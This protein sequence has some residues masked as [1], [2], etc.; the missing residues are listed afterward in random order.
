[1]PRPSVIF[2]MCLAVCAAFSTA[3][4]A[5]GAC[6]KLN[7][8][9][10]GGCDGLKATLDLKACADAGSAAAPKIACSGE[11]ATVTVVT[12]TNTYVGTAELGAESWGKRSWQAKEVTASGK[13]SGVAAVAASAAEVPFKTK[14]VEKKRK[15]K[16]RRTAA[17]KAAK[18]APAN[19]TATPP[20]ITP[21]PTIVIAPE[22]E[23]PP[24]A[25]P[26]SPAATADSIPA[27]AAPP[28]LA[29][30][31]EPTPVAAPPLLPPPPAPAPEPTPA[32]APPTPPP[33]PEPAPIVVSVPAASPTPVLPEWMRGLTLS[34][35]ADFYYSY[36]T[37]RP[38]Q[39]HAAPAAG[40]D[41][42]YHGLDRTQTPLRNFDMR[43]NQITLNLAEFTIKRVNDAS[44]LRLDFDFGDMADATHKDAAGRVDEVSKHIGQ[45]IIGYS[46]AALDGFTI[47]VGKMATHLGYEVTKAKDNWQYSRSFVF[48]LAIPYWHTGASF[49]YVPNDKVSSALFVY[50]GWNSV[51]D[52]NT[53]KTIGLQV[54]GTPVTGVSIIYNGITGPEQNDDEKDKKTVHEMIATWTA[55]DCL[56]VAADFV[57]GTSQNEALVS[58]ENGT[59]HWSGLQA[60][61]K[62]TIDPVFSVSP[63][64]ESYW[65]GD[66]YTTGVSQSLHELTVT[67]AATLVAGLETRLE[68]RRDLA[69]HEAFLRGKDP[70]KDQTTM[71]LGMLSSF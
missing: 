28:A 12:A 34:A 5:L 3:S 66:G 70:A 35:Y 16:K 23:A 27:A 26:E 52:N 11:K 2:S 14:P 33:A 69:N 67:G 31:A 62:W 59:A 25:A 56:A 8:T 18:P 49:A 24:A 42:S 60:A 15:E 7:V 30:A 43:H 61:L 41:T 54:A 44:S 19:A 65:D 55:S 50:N 17:A 29:A 13:G 39:G 1:M 10:S 46:P 20:I 22:A 47:S 9:G 21:E 38:Y 6:P 58:G 37:N 45:A 64:L 71:T 51:A 4:I 40:A 36:N 32:G 63:R 48:A 53:G 68:V 57:A